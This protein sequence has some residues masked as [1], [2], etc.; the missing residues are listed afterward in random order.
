MQGRLR[1]TLIYL[2]ASIYIDIRAPDDTLSA[3]KS[4]R[5]ELE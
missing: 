5:Q 2:G 1:A 4:A 3:S